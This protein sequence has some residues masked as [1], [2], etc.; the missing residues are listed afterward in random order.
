MIEVSTGG[1]V[2][3]TSG[4][5]SLPGGRHLEYRLH[6][7]D[8]PKCRDF[9]D[10]LRQFMLA[11]DLKRAEIESLFGVGRAMVSKYLTQG[12]DPG[13]EK[14]QALCRRYPA[15]DLK[16]LRNLVNGIKED[17]KVY[18]VRTEFGAKIGRIAES[19]SDEALKFAML[20]LI[21]ALERE[22]REPGKGTGT[23]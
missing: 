4:S 2:L 19:V 20:Q 9:A 17:E 12:S 1:V 7:V 15:Y 14:L 16:Q 23:K 3:S 13:D 6:M 21:S 8:I 22:T 5:R 18:T 11:E 10:F